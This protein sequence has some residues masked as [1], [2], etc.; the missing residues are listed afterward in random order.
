MT[1]PGSAPA[2][3]NRVRTNSETAMIAFARRKNRDGVDEA[4]GDAT[5]RVQGV[6]A[7]GGV[8][9]VKRREER[10]RAKACAR[11]RGH[12]E[13]ASGPKCAWTTSARPEPAPK[14]RGCRA[15]EQSE[16]RDFAKPRGKDGDCLDRDS[17][18][19][20]VDAAGSHD[21]RRVA[22]QGA[23]LVHDE[24]LAVA[25]E[26]AAEDQDIRLPR[27]SDVIWP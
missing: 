17:R 2:A 14:S 18:Q 15:V 10:C 16:L 8:E 20:Q 21:G 23:R 5:E 25:Q 27:V 3:T 4:A 24:G 6:I 11:Q 22:M 12:E 1:L 26:F 7:V 19:G 9:S 13:A